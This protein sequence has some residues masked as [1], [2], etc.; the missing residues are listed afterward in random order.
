MHT[1]LGSIKGVVETCGSTWPQY[2]V[3]TDSGLVIDMN[4]YSKV[5]AGAE[6]FVD[7]RSLEVPNHI[8]GGRIIDIRSVGGD[9]I[10][11]LLEN[12]SVIVRELYFN[13]D[14]G[15]STPSLCFLRNEDY[16]HGSAEH[17]R[18]TPRVSLQYEM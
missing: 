15:E 14:T 1:K 2:F 16:E 18:G 3:L 8:K 5:L 7:G 10:C 9:D 4:H 6:I 11:L 17:F 12:N 13:F